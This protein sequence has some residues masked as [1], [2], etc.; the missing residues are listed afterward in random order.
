MKALEILL[1]NYWIVKNNNPQMYYQVKDGLKQSQKFIQ[2]KLGYQL[3]VN[4]YLI[5]LEKITDNLQ[6]WMGIQEF[7]DPIEYQMLCYTLM[8]LDDKEVGQQ[9][10]LSDITQFIA[11]QFNGEIDWTV[12]AVRRQLVNVIQYC[13]KMGMLL[14]TDGD[15]NL[16]SQN[17]TTEVLY[18]N[19]GISRYFL[20]NF[21][22]DILNVKSTEQFHEQ[23]H[24]FLD[25]ELGMAR[26]YR[27]YRTLLMCPNLSYSPIQESDFAYVRNYRNQI[28]SDFES[29]LNCS[30]HVHLSDAY[31]VINEMPSFGKSFPSNNSLD[32][33]ICCLFTELADEIRFTRQVSDQNFIFDTSSL[34]EIIKEGILNNME[35]LAKKYRDLKI[36]V[37]VDLVIDQ[38]QNY[39]FIE[40]IDDCF[41][42][43]SIIGKIEGNFLR[44]EKNE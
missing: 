31:L 19:T 25:H 17:I 34:Y 20:R 33:L 4:P 29:F 27:V 10:I 44:S 7:K 12:Y 30:L 3:I 15:G 43:N 40:K 41:I 18:E 35:S 16:F 6:S 37:L 2:E 9:F 5:K 1:N 42:I 28:K 23:H 13:L 22:F 36:H 24:F 8:F 14:E 26:R 38:M 39:G 32:E 21:G 11:L